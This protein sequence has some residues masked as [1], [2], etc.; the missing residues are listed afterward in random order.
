LKKAYLAAGLLIIFIAFAVSYESLTDLDEF[1][2][3]LLFGNEFLKGFSWFGNTTTAFGIGV[4]MMIWQLFVRNWHGAIFALSS[5]AGATLINQALKRVFERPRPEMIDQL[6]SFSFP[7]G[8]S[9]MSVGYLVV[10]AYL[11]AQY[12]SSRSIQWAIYIFAI[13]LIACVGLSRIA[14]GYHYLTDV[15]AGWCLAGAWVVVCIIGYEK[16]KKVRV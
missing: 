13:L 10:L 14:Y 5:V 11:L 4:A 9:M 3:S 15:L 8:H 2:Y 7:S 12:F 16:I 1:G 6:E